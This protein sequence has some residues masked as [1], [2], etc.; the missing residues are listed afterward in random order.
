MD[1]DGNVTVM[2]D[3]DVPAL[4]WSDGVTGRIQ[5]PDWGQTTLAPTVAPTVYTND[6]SSDSSRDGLGTAGIVIIVV[7]VVVILLLVGALLWRR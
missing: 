1:I 4:V 2:L 5:G 6:A 3:F 7:L